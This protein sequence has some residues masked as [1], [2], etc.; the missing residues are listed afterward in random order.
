MIDQER[1]S[2]L[3][4][5]SLFVLGNLWIG[6]MLMGLSLLEESTVWAVMICV[7]GWLGIAIGLSASLGMVLHQL[8]IPLKFGEHPVP[9]WPKWK[10]HLV[11]LFTFWGPS[12]A[13]FSMILFINGQLD[14]D[15]RPEGN[16][17]KL[18]LLQAF[19]F[20]FCY[21]GT[22]WYGVF[23]AT[24][25]PLTTSVEDREGDAEMLA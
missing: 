2:K 7:T 22:S 6:L 20:Y 17:G 25:H 9:P 23:Q 16:L 10:I 15:L 11:G 3:R 24:R 21:V 13:V 19:A 8:K 18:S 14:K 1:M 4:R 5:T 12:L